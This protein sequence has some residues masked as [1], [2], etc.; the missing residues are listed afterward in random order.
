LLV[1]GRKIVWSPELCFR[2]AWYDHRICH[3]IGS[4]RVH[5]ILMYC[6]SWHRFQTQIWHNRSL[7]HVRSDVLPSR[8]SYKSLS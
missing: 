6:D 3:S 8:V 5:K 4:K 1:G 2:Q 7:I